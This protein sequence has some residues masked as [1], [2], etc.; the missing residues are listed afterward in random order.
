MNVTVCWRFR[1]Q[2]SYTTV[3]DVCQRNGRLDAA[4][5]LL[6]DMQAEGIAPSPLTYKSVIYGCAQ[7]VRGHPSRHTPPLTSAHGLHVT[8]P[9]PAAC[10]PCYRATGPVLW[11]CCGTCRTTVGCHRT[12]SPTPRSSTH[13]R[14]PNR[15]ATTSHTHPSRHLS[16]SGQPRFLDSP[17][18]LVMLWLLVALNCGLGRWTLPW[19]CWRR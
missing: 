9:S 5:Q 15:W 16:L 14:R 11:S 8:P 6:Q 7:A 17:R 19:A 18:L 10:L 4:L 13:A 12:S 1:R 2:M 3:I